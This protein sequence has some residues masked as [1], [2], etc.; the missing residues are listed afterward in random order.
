MDGFIFFDIKNKNTEK[1][2]ILLQYYY[3]NLVTYVIE[4]MQRKSVIKEIIIMI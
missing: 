3:I 1:K 2:Y 4:K